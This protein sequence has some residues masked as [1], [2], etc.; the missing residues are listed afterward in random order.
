MFGVFIEPIGGEITVASESALHKS[1]PKTAKENA[2][3]EQ[4]KA[5]RF[6][7][8]SDT[9]NARGCYYT[10]IPHVIKHKGIDV[11][12]LTSLNLDKVSSLL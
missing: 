10:S 5:S 2:L 11:Q 1:T 4:L 3:D 8:A 12:Q 6:S 9:S 7:T